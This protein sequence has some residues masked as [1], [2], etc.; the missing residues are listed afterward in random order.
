[1]ND[2]DLVETRE[3]EDASR[4]GLTVQVGYMLRYNPAFGLCFRL[5]R[6]R[7]LGDVFAIDTTMSKAVD[8]AVRRQFLPYRGGAMFEIGCHVIDAVVAILGRPSK[9][10]A[11]L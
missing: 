2:E 8:A 6:E 7:Y 5:V 1:M 9:I 10:T 11:S 4:R 3:L